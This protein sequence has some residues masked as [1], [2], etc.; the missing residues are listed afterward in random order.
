MSHT[1]QLRRPGRPAFTLVEMLVST[2]LIMF[3]MYIIAAAFEKGIESFRTL[4]TAGDMQDRLRAASTILRVD[5]TRQHFGNHLLVS[6]QRLDQQDWRI[7]TPSDE[8]G[9]F[10]IYQTDDGYPTTIQIEGSDPDDPSLKVT[11]GN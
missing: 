8:G 9:Y 11:R 3:M 5:L 1:T 6:D 10:R 4:K 7:N 2:A